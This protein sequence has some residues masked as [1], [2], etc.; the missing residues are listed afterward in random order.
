M[1][2]R[3]CFIT[4]TYDDPHLPPGRT[5]VVKDWQLFAKRMRKK[6]GPFRFFHCGEYTEDG[7]PHYHAALFGLDFPDQLFLKNSKTK[8]HP[9][10]TSAVLADLWGKGFHTIGEL[11]FDSAAYVARYCMKKIT[12]DQAEKHYEYISEE[13]EGLVLSRKPEYTTMSRNKGIGESW[14]HKYLNDVYPSDEVII[15]GKSAQPPK[16]YDQFLAKEYPARAKTLRKKRLQSGAKQA[17]NN[18]PDRLET[19]EVCHTAKIKEWT[20]EL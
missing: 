12:G 1:H 7:R 2:T 19:R 6:L 5:L 4:L 15:N 8:G 20:R 13:H 17:S 11:S 14:I 9:L 10:Y 18:T 3:N 16:F